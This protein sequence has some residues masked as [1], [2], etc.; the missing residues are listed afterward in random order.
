M[1]ALMPTTIKVQKLVIRYTPREGG[2]I[3]TDGLRMCKITFQER[4]E[5]SKEYGNKEKQKEIFRNIWRS[6]DE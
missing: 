4:V 5:I 2:Y 6:R 1:V 3:A